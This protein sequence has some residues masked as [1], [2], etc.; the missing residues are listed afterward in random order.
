MSALKLVS[1][2]IQGPLPTPSHDLLLQDISGWDSLKMVQLVLRLEDILNRELSESEMEGLS[3]ISDL[4]S[5][6]T[7]G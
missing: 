5:L 3:A 6:L 1:D 4:D 7:A 2:I